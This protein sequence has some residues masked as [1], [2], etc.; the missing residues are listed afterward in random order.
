MKRLLVVLIAAKY[1]QIEDGRS[2]FYW[3]L[4][5]CVPSVP[6]TPLALLWANFVVSLE[7]SNGSVQGGH[8]LCI[9][10]DRLCIL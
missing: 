8:L 2:G 7:V 3:S 10:P 5:S 9:G 1:A 6:V 4:H